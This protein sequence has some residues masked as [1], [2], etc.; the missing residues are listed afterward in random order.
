MIDCYRG[1]E[2]R[3]PDIVRH[4]LFVSFFPLLIAGPVERAGNLMPQLRA[5]QRPTAADWSDG[6]SLFLAGLFKKLALADALAVYVNRV[7]QGPEGFASSALLLAVFAYAWQIYFDFSGYSDMA[8]GVARLFGIRVMLNFNHPYLATSLTDFWRR[9]HISLSLWFRDYVYIPLG[10]NR[11]GALRASLNV[12]LTM[13]ISGLWHGAAWTFVI[14]GAIHGVGSVLTRSLD[15]SR[16]YE[17]RVPRLVKQMLCFLVVCF[18]WV[19]FR[20]PDFATART[21]VGRVFS[22]NMLTD[23]AFPLVML[24]FCLAAWLYQM[25]FESRV[26]AL[27]ALAPVRVGMAAAMIAYLVF[28]TGSGGLFVYGAM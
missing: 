17:N 4:A 25:A 8:R 24:L 20:A 27:L 22:T 13:L 15:R 9:W 26:R 7:Y 2:R 18:G 5:T 3:E 21:I 16:F 23:P 14:W 1:R 28:F 11:K 6:L 10:G 19:F 12:F